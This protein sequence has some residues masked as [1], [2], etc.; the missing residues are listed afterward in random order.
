[1]G[2]GEGRR[3]LGAV[4]ICGG[5]RSG[6]AEERKGRGEGEE[7]GADR[8]GHSVS[9]RGKCKE[10]RGTRAAARRAKV[11]WWAAGPRGRGEMLFF[12][13]FSNAFQI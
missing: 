8:L 7:G 10:E 6:R 11:G 4:R 13:S 1:M 2:R 9:D 12:F 3:H 5:A